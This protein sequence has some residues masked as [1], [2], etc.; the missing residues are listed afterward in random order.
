VAWVAAG[1]LAIDG[2]HRKVLATVAA[3][4]PTLARLDRIR[5]PRMSVLSAKRMKE[6]IHLAALCDMRA[7]RA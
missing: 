2:L 6:T 3:R 4:R 5:F 1:A 7:R